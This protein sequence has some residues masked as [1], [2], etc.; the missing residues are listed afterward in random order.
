MLDAEMLDTA[1]LN[2]EMLDTKLLDT[3][4]NT[5]GKTGLEFLTIY[6]ESRSSK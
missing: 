5:S 3:E 1:V 2:T 4:V 6:P